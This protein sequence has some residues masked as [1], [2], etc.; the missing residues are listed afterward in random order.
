VSSEE[1]VPGPIALILAALSYGERLARRRAEENVALA[2]DFRTRR[3]QQHVAERERENASLLEAR[4]SEIGSM[5]LERVFRPFLDAFFEHTQPADWLEAQTWH[6]VGDALVRD[7]ADSLI[8][9]LD[10]ISAE[11]TR[12]ALAERDEQESFALDEITRLVEG[13]PP[14]A[15]R[16]A[17][18]ARRVIGE[19]L[20]QTRR[21]LNETGALRSLLGSDEVEK[22][23]LLNL[24]QRHRER[25][26][27]LGIE[28]VD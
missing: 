23:F 4:L 19:A 13:D 21:A 16:V 12:R 25:L 15:E 5:E 2:P 17:A 11:V 22:R 26:D 27:R 9:V 1:S 28:L 10:R 14:A 20:T 6:Y 3:N 8:P 18:Y 7:F 24:L